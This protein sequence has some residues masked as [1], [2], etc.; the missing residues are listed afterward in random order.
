VLYEVSILIELITYY[1]ILKDKL[2][3]AY[4]KMFVMHCTNK[5]NACN[6]FFSKK[7]KKKTA[8]RIMTE[9]CSFLIVCFFF[10]LTVCDAK[11]L[12]KIFLCFTFSK[13]PDLI[14]SILEDGIIYQLS[15]DQ[16]HSKDLKIH[17][18]KKRKKGF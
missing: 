5:Q 15:P 14:F 10:Y 9:Y 17:Q 3:N 7:K 12:I 2:H 16:C 4:F 1:P 11:G 6:A 18:I 8:L 13:V